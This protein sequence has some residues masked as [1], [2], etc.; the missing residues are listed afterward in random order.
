MHYRYQ[1]VIINHSYHCQKCH[2]EPKIP[3]LNHKWA[4]FRYQGHHELQRHL[5]DGRLGPLSFDDAVL[6]RSF[7]DVKL[8]VALLR[9]PVPTT[10]EWC[11]LTMAITGFMWLIPWSMADNQLNHGLYVLS[12]PELR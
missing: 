1:G 4:Y 7:V 6:P 2:D 10:G 11:D 12:I 9:A 8:I 5:Y 3:I